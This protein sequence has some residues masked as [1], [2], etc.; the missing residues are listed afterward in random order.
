M[1]VAAATEAEVDNNQVMVINLVVEVEE[2]D[3]HMVVIEVAEEVEIEAAEEVVAEE[4]TQML[5]FSS[6]TW[7]THALIEI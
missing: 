3:L 6:E 4:E 7:P 1:E 5:L 2:V